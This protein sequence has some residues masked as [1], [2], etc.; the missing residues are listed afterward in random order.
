MAG[1]LSNNFPHA[2][3]HLY[4]TAED[5][6]FDDLT[7][8]EWRDE[9]FDVAYVPMGKGGKEYRERLNGLSTGLGIGETFG[10]IG[11]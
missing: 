1:F 5:D 8:E 7:L 10:I 6:D 9:G 2:S 4:F 11:K 3:P